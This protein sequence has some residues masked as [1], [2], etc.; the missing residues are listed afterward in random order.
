[1]CAACVAQGAVYAGG[2]LAGLQVLAARAR[3]RRV[4]EAEAADT[5]E[6]DT[7][8]ESSVTGVSSG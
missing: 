1:M 5:A 6:A 3:H 2:A 4:A 8:S 7:E